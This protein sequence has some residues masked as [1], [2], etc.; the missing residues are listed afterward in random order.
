MKKA[1]SLLLVLAMVLGLAACGEKPEETKGTDPVG[2]E[3]NPTEKEVKYKDM[4]TVGVVSAWTTCDPTQN[5]G[6]AGGILTCCSH[7]HLV[8]YNEV[9]TKVD[10]LLAESYEISEGGKVFTFKLRKGVKFHDGSDFTVDDVLFTILDRGASAEVDG[11]VKDIW[12][13]LEKAEAVDADTVKLTLK[14][15][16]P[17]FIIK[18]SCNAGGVMVSK[19]AFEKDP[20]NGGTIGTGPYV[21]KDNVLNDYALYERFDGYWGEA[22]KTKSIKFRYIPEN[23]SRL[24]ALENGEIDI[25]N[26]VD[27]VDLPYVKDN[28]DLVLEQWASG[29][30][31]YMYLNPQ[32]AP[33]DDVNF[34]KAIAY[35]IDV[36]A[37]IA[38]ALNGEGTKSL[39]CASPT[40]FGYFDDWASVGMEPYHQDA[41]KAKEYLEKSKYD[42][43]VTFEISVNNDARLLVAQQI[44]DQI[45]QILGINITAQK[46]DSAGFGAVQKGMEWNALISSIGYTSAGDD[47]RRTFG[48]GAGS[49]KGQYSFPDLDALLDQAQAETD[50]AKRLD[51]Y[52]QVQIKIHDYCPNINMYLNSS[53]AAVRK[54]VEGCYFEARGYLDYSRAFCVVE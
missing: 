12:T 5:H 16:D 24:I 31:N 41:A 43:S 6:T 36:D 54:G 15:A 33:F 27:S 51:L 19:K 7:E 28:K 37:I 2:S 46:Y 18:M 20:A 11:D 4:L 34:R 38:G 42:S 40:Q 17:D 25:C 26:G 35:C 10:C 21:L 45:K 50:S 13:L 49:N 14:V 9:T 30:L 1:L 3:A 29:S 23:S 32:V 22:P 44:Q 52:K 53:A 47:I 8:K 39:A 48:T